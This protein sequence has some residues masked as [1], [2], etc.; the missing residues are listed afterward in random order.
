[1]IESMT[2]ARF[3]HD[4]LELQGWDVR[5]ADA[6]KARGIAPLACKTDRIDCWV[7]AELARRDLIPEIWLPGPRGAG[8]AGAGPLPA[9]PGA[10]SR[11]AEKPGARDPLP[12]RD[13]QQPQR[14]VRR[15]RPP[16]ARAAAATRAVAVDGCLLAG[17]DRHPQHRDPRLRARA[18]PA[19]RRPPLRLPARHLSG[20]RLG[21]RLHDRLRDRRHRPL[22][23]PRKLVGYTGLCPRVDQSGERDRRGPLRKNGPTYL[24]W[25][26]IEAAHVAVRCHPPYRHLACDDFATAASAA[27]NIIRDRTGRRLSESIWH[28]L[29]NDQPFAPA[30]APQSESD[31]AQPRRGAVRGRT[32]GPGGLEPP[33]DGL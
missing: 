1:M 33:T 17:A 30:G 5:I 26:L 29:T 6:M 21:T 16:D 13:R 31:A 9:A 32:M 20:H 12:A 25:A 22:P 4:Q 28:M 3:V 7:L 27:A 24:R 8:R 14:P 10:P 23:D 15:R 2:G 11:L 19:W 18:R